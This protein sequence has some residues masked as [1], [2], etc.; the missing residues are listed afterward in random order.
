MDCEVREVS[1]GTITR[2]AGMAGAA[3][4]GN[5]GDGGPAISA[6]IN[7]AN[8]GAVGGIAVDADQNVFVSDWSNNRVRKIGLGAPSPPTNVT[9]SAGNAR[10]TVSWQA[11]ASNGGS[12]IGAYTATASPGGAR[13]T[14]G[15]TS[16]APVVLRHC[17]VTGLHNGTGYRFTVT[18]ESS[19]GTSGPSAP[20]ASVTPHGALSAQ[21]S[22]RRH[23]MGL[24]AV[25]YAGTH[26]Y[27]VIG[28]RK[29]AKTRSA[30]CRLTGKGKA[31]RARCTLGLTP[32]TW[33]LTAEAL[34]AASHVIAKTTHVAVVR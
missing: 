27:L 9:A 2:F 34:N 12:P 22:L 23:T 6:E 4:C 32:G 28:V 25:P 24:A 3:A 26:R 33:T 19:G 8:V 7:G 29:H 13:C 14:T 18:A 31:R 20:S 1:G 5:T 30:V 10:A 17:T 16:S 11:P 21:W 15:A